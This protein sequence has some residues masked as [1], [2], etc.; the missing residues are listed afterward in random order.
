[1]IL[2][3]QFVQLAEYIAS[4]HFTSNSSK[5]SFVFQQRP[6]L[7]FSITCCIIYPSNHVGCDFFECRLRHGRPGVDVEVSQMR[8]K[9]FGACEIE[10]KE[11][12]SAL[13]WNWVPLRCQGA[14]KHIPIF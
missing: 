13:W 4:S 5:F 1:M 6:Y 14:T 3:W 10:S 2:R 7:T 9:L 12:H 8:K 11:F